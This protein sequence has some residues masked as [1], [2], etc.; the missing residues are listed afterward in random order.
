MTAADTPPGLRARVPHED[1]HFA[2]QLVLR[3]WWDGMNSPDQVRER[4]LLL[5]RLFFQHFTPGSRVL[6]TVDGTLV[7]FLVGF[8][9]DTDPNSAYIHFVGVRPDHR[10]AGLA[11][12]LYGAFFAYAREHDRRWVH[13]ITSPAN[14]R[15]LAFHTDLGFTIDRRDTA[16][17]G[18]P[19]HPDYDG[20]GIARV[21]F[22]RDLLG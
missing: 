19:V 16:V 9:S 4:Q 11:S 14:R 18:V 5:P 20:P 15:S 3:E 8:L 1:D 13:A 17:D 22:T 2:V 7:A 21:T 12:W 10:R 6:E